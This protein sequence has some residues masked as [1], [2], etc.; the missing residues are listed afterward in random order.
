VASLGSLIVL[1]GACAAEPTTTTSSDM[2]ASASAQIT[3]GPSAIATP[4]HREPEVL[5][6]IALPLPSAQTQG[7]G[8][9]VTDEAIFLTAYSDGSAYL[10]RVDLA[11]NEVTDIALD[12]LACLAAAGGAVWM[13]SPC[14]ALQGPPPSVSLSR[15]DL[16][17]GQP[18]LVVELDSVS[19]FAFGLGGVWAADG[20]LLLLDGES[21]AVMRRIPWSSFGLQVGCGELWGWSQSPD[22]RNPGWL[23]DRLDPLTGDVL[24]EFVMPDTVSPSLVEIDGVCWTHGPSDLYGVAPGADLVVRESV[25]ATQFAGATSWTTTERG[26]VQQLDPTT[27]DVWGDAW[28]LP[29]QDLHLDPKG[30]PDW[31]LQSAGGSLWLLGGDQIVR[32]AIPTTP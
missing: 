22:E 8:V 30:R 24:E 11:T 29:P 4:A 25:G 12:D 15:V 2:F 16:G 26:V 18:R 6:R 31:L 3:A 17:T 13:M 1:G 23:L 20:Q 32:Y 19:A 10:A 21:G 9:A 7:I 28:Q 14:G 27:G 5:A